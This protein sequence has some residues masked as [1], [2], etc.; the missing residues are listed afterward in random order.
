MQ[1]SVSLPPSAPDP[2][3]PGLIS[4]FDHHAILDARPTWT[5]VWVG[6]E[7]LDTGLRCACGREVVAD[8]ESPSGWAHVGVGQEG[9]LTHYRIWLEEQ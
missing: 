1:R 8:E 2:H 5:E 3:D 6:D 9:D 7:C 4:P